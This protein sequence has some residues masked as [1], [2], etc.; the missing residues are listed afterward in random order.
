MILSYI[1]PSISPGQLRAQ[2]I[3][4]LKKIFDSLSLLISNYIFP[5]IS[6]DDV[7]SQLQKIAPVAEITNRSFCIREHFPNQSDDSTEYLCQE[8]GN[9]HNNF[10]L[11]SFKGSKYLYINQRAVDP[12]DL[13]SVNKQEWHSFL[14]GIKPIAFISQNMI[15]MLP[16]NV[17][18]DSVPFQS[19]LYL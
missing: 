18:P 5:C 15:D 16:T 13:V 1:D 6:L 3:S 4:N 17:M 19:I 8:Y 14:E 10:F 2:H 12:Q 11:S 7:L 9:G